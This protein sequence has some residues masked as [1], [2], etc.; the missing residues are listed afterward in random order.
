M[1]LDIILRITQV[2]AVCMDAFSAVF[3][4]GFG[5]LALGQL[6]FLMYRLLMTDKRKQY[7]GGRGN[8]QEKTEVTKTETCNAEGF[9]VFLR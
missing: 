8:L 6:V 4:V 9:W 7:V 2:A 3:G 1:N 5:P